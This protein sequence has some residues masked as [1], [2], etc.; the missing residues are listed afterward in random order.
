M[1]FYFIIF[2]VIGFIIAKTNEEDKNAI[3]ILIAIATFWALGSGF[4]WGFVCLGEMFVGYSIKRIYFK[5]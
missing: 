1:F 3:F 2:V 4:V 5:N